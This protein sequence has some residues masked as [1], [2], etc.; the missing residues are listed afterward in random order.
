MVNIVYPK[1]GRRRTLREVVDYH[2]VLN[3]VTREDGCVVFQGS[4]GPRGY[5]QV[6]WNKKP[7]YLHRLVCEAQHGPAPEGKPHV[8]H[9][10]GKGKEGCVAP[11][12]L[13]WS[14]QRDN[15]RENWL[16]HG[17]YGNRKRDPRRV[18]LA[19]KLH[20]LGAPV[21]KLAEAAGMCCTAMRAVL[22]RKSYQWVE[23]G[24]W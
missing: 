19:R 9:S 14:S 21:G 6:T 20:E 4:R 15:N 22:A 3:T 10:C 18:R 5:A 16:V 1:K 2:L 8:S 23:E 17:K 24:S 7:Q 12:H 11:A 13:R